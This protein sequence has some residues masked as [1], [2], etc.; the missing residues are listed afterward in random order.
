MSCIFGCRII[1]FLEIIMDVINE[2]KLVLE[3]PR[4]DRIASTAGK[5]GMVGAIGG[6]LFGLGR[7][8][9]YDEVQSGFKSFLSNL[10]KQDQVAFVKKVLEPAKLYGSGGMGA[11]AMMGAGRAMMGRRGQSPTQAAGPAG[12][13]QPPQHQLLSPQRQLV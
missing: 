10:D 3:G 9:E 1:I 2:I 13:T 5:A 11:G 6:A 12:P 7:A 4:F 8:L